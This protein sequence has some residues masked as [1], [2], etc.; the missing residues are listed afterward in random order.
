MTDNLK[1]IKDLE[2][3]SITLSGT[4]SSRNIDSFDALL[5]ENSR[6][7]RELAATKEENKR[8]KEKLEQP[9]SPQVSALPKTPDVK[10]VTELPQDTEL[11]DDTIIRF[12]LLELK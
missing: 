2:A 9:Q 3:R 6:L 8:L 10:T 7:K 1:F 5:T 4:R 11:P 12:G